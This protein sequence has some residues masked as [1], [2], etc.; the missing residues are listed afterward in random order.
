[1]K[2]L[3]TAALALGMVA[4]LAGA[5]SAQDRHDG[6]HDN[7][8]GPPDNRGHGRDHDRGYD[9]HRRHQDWHKGGRV[10][11]DEWRRGE[12]I[13]YRTHH[14]RRPPRGYEWRQVDGD[15]VLGAIATGLIVDLLLNNR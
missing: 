7:G 6:Y 11:R 10:D 8:R 14:L 4:G 2:R 13:D 12:R 15:Y 1:M 3:L 9:N 5:A